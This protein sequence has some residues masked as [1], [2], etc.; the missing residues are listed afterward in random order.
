M[1][2]LKGLATTDNRGAFV[3]ERADDKGN[4]AILG[5]DECVPLHELAAVVGHFDRA[6]V[7]D[8]AQRARLGVSLGVSGEVPGNVFHEL[9]AN[10]SEAGCKQ[11]RGEIGSAAAERHDAIALAA[12][13]ESRRHDHV[14]TIEQRKKT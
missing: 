4:A 1:G 5:G 10:C 7:R 8:V 14:V 11:H 12:R 2:P 13:Q 3:A 6:G 9:A